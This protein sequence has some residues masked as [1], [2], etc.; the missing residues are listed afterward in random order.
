MIFSVRQTAIRKLM[1]RNLHHPEMLTS[2]QFTLFQQLS[3]VYP[4]LWP[5]LVPLWGE[6]ELLAFPQPVDVV[7]PRH[8]C[9]CS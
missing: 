1:R 3:E 8:C 6:A 4:I 2:Y 7:C 9:C 5:L